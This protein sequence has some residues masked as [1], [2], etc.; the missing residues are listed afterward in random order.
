MSTSEPEGI[1]GTFQSEHRVE[2][3]GTG[4]V[5]TE[6][7]TSRA[8]LDPKSEFLAGPKINETVAY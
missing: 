5:I 3:I 1:T 4:K 2:S 8:S 6:G 7:D